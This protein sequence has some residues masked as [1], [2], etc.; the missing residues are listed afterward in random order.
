MTSSGPQPDRTTDPA[1]NEARLI[2]KS[3]Q[4]DAGAFTE[5]VF[6]HQARVRAYVGGT[7]SRADV[8]DDLAQ[9]VFLSAFSSL[10]SYKGDAPFGVWLLGIARHK[11]LMYLRHEVRR[12]AR[13]TRSLE[14][15]LVDLKLRV[16]EQDEM[17]LP[18][19]ERE[20][21]ALQRCLERLPAS[22]AE[23]IAER[24]F[25]AR[26]ISD[27]ARDLGKREGTIRMSLLRLRQALR[28]CMEQRLAK[29]QS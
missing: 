3:R 5:L 23:M 12:L 10:E 29:E 20:I 15:V 26:S 24:Y 6:L 4:G 16:L 28:A 8:V 19:R 11:T 27:M 18:R 1:E 9:E 2:D 25:K 22:G 21:T 7:I 13:E 14:T 17:D